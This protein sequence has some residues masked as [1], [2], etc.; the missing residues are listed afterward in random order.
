MKYALLLMP[1]LASCGPGRVWSCDFYT[2]G[3]CVSSAL[4]VDPAEVEQVVEA[5]EDVSNQ[6]YR[7]KN[8]PQTLDKH[9]VRVIMTDRHLAS[10]CKHIDADVYVC[11]ALGGVN[12][13]GT[14]LYVEY[15]GGCLAYTALAHELLHSVDRYYLGGPHGHST[16]FMFEQ[17]ADDP[18]LTIERKVFRLLLKTLP[19]CQPKRF[20]EAL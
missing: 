19:S 1:L 14:K 20:K 3:L 2:A 12:F 13:G 4:E 18:E 8:L 7:V 5:V 15:Y 10:D 11:D 6:Y 9:D 17:A 16:P